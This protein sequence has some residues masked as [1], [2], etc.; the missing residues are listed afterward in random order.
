M[1]KTCFGLLRHGQTEWNVAGR[2]QGLCDS[3]LTLFGRE[4]IAAWG[5]HLKSIGWDRIIHS[6]LGRTTETAALLNEHLSL[7]ISSHDGLREQSWGAWETM[8]R[9][10]IESRYP[11]ELAKRIKLGWDFCA[12]EGETRNQVYTRCHDTLLT[13]AEKYPGESILIITHQ[14][15]IKSLIYYLAGRKYLPDEPKLLEKNNLQLLTLENDLLTI[16]QLNLTKKSK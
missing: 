10:E 11:G 9:G 7:P 16:K 3:P 5:T 15:V 8:T 13:M 1:P 6:P 14:G 12:P 4:E 2:V